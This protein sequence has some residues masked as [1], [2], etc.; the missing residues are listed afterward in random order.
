MEGISQ[1]VYTGRIIVVRCSGN[2]EISLEI[3]QPN[4]ILESSHQSRM[5][6]TIRKRD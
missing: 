1:E 5:I 2:N 3:I 6:N 4:K